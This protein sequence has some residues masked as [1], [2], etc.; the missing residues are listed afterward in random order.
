MPSM[1]TRTPLP[2]VRGRGDAAADSHDEPSPMPYSV[3]TAPGAEAPLARLAEFTIPAAVTCGGERCSAS[4]VY[5][6]TT[7]A[8]SSAVELPQLPRLRRVRLLAHDIVTFGA[9]SHR[10]DVV[11]EPRGLAPNRRESCVQ[12]DLRFISEN[13]DPAH[14]IGIRPNRVVNTSEVSSQVAASVF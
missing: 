13:L 6:T 10:Q 7:T 5:P 1:V 9:Y 2:R 11:G 14:T 4:T 12:L 3:T 8:I